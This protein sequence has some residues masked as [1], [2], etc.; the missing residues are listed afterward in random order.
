MDPDADGDDPRDNE[1]DDD[2]DDDDDEDEADTS[3]SRSA[4]S[5]LAHA[6]GAKVFGGSSCALTIS[7]PDVLMRF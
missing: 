1:D 2:D 6:D 7:H 4:V 5:C 3:C